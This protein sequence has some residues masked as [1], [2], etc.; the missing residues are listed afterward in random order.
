MDFQ[1]TVDSQDEDA[2]LNDALTPE[3]TDASE[4]RAAFQRHLAD[5]EAAAETNADPIGQALSHIIA[6]TMEIT[7]TLGDAIKQALPT[8]VATLD[9]LEQVKSPLNDFFRASR[10]VD[11]FANFQ[12]R[13]QQER[14]REAEARQAK[15]S[16]GFL[17]AVPGGG[18]PRSSQ[19]HRR[20]PI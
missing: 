2:Q 19:R 20:R 15:R 1:H 9:D 11:R 17:P 8:A 16:A 3:P 13:L 4:H 12:L 10:Q 18:H 5:Y 7:A 14:M 6:D